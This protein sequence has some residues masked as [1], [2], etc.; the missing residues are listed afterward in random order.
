MYLNPIMKTKKVSIR[1]GFLRN[2]FSCIQAPDKKNSF[3]VVYTAVLSV[4][5][6][7]KE[8]FDLVNGMKVASWHH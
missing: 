4:R 1:S 8:S 3:F 2:Q 6:E 5:C 7:M